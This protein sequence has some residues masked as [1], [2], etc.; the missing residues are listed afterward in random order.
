M[1]IIKRE[2]DSEEMIAPLHSVCVVV[3]SVIGSVIVTRLEVVVIDRFEIESGS[4]KLGF[5][6]FI[7]SSVF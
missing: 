7:L 6:E 4:N 3:F 2:S 5:S 1:R